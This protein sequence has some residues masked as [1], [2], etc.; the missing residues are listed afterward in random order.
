[1]SKRLKGGPLSKE[2]IANIVKANTGRKA[3]EETRKKLS[4]S[5]KGIVQSEE[6][7]KKRSEAIRM[8]WVK[9]KSSED[10]VKS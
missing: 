5:H 7:K 4:E 1:M 9:R 3:S 2:H 10:I 6:S 8:W